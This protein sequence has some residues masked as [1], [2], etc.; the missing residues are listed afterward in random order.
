MVAKLQQEPQM[1][2]SFTGVTAPERAEFK[3]WD[4]GRCTFV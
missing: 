2:W 3:D 4:M 1:A